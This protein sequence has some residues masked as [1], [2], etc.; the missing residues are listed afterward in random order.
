VSFVLDASI[1]LTCCFPDEEAQKAQEVSE[2]IATGD[3]VLVPGF[4]PH[5]IL[6][7]LLVGEKRE[8]LTP[9][10]TG[11]FIED[12][13]HLPNVDHRITGANACNGR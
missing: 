12:L 2:R 13:K 3:P 7:A 1:V 6:N 11:A 4:W 10:L 9:E 5:E 8:R